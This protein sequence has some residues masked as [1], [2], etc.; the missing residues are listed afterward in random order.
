[1]ATSRIVQRLVAG[2]VCLAMFFVAGCASGHTAETLIGGRPVV[3]RS[4]V[5]TQPSMKVFDQDTATFSVG[6]FKFTIDRTRVTWGRDQTLALPANWKRVEFIDKGSYIAVH[7]DGTAL[8]E[9]RPAA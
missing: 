9:I 4:S 5:D 3:Y 2:V 7:V 1:M 6:E 8:G